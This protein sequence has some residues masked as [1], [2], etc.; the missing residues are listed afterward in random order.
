MKV[1]PVK[2]EQIFCV[3]CQSNYKTKTAEEGV[4]FTYLLT[5]PQEMPPVDAIHFDLLRVFLV[6]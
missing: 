5:D 2:R 3:P 4:A 1:L 6:N